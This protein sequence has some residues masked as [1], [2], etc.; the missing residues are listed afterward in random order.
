MTF[1]PMTFNDETVI[2]YVDGEL[3]EPTR[4]AVDAALASDPALAQRVAQHRALRERVQKE[5]APVLREAVPERLMAATRGISATAGA[6]NIIPLKHTPRA[7]WSWPQWGAIAASLF[8]GILI[9]PFLW[10]Q[11]TG[12]VDIRSGRILATGT[13]AQALSQQL[14]GNQAADTPV[15]VGISF[16]SR[17]G[18]YCRTFILRDR[19]TLGGIACREQ[20][21]WIL[22]ALAN[23]PSPNTSGE[24]RP[25]ASSLPPSIAQTVTDLIAGEPLDANA[26]A[27]ARAKG[28]QK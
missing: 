17:S 16:V 10:R 24:Y 13:L 26:E 22:T 8:I 28:W 23:A 21:H 1:T 27:S 25:A 11:P 14:A 4:A 15:H 6:S 18:N 9:A 12:A 5:F 3:D 20:G 2:A 19:N 7:R